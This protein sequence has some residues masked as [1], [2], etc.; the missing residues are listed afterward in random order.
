MNSTNKYFPDIAI[1]PGDHLIEILESIGM[2]QVELAER[3]GRPIKTINEIV[4]GKAALTPETALQLERVLNTPMKYWMNLESNYRGTLARIQDKELLLE[5]LAWLKA[6]PIKQMISYKWIAEVKEPFSQLEEVLRFF[7]VASIK[8]WEKVWERKLCGAFSYRKSEKCGMDNIALSTWLRKGELEASKIECGPY[9][10]ATF[11]KILTEFRGLTKVG[12]EVFVNELQKKCA[13]TGVAV[14]FVQELPK[15]PVNGVTHWVSSKK[16]VIQLSLRY[17]T[18]DQLW[19]SFF[20]EAGHI[21]VHGK[22]DFVDNGVD[23]EE[24][25]VWE[26]E[27][28]SFAADKLIPNSAYE[29]FIKCNVFSEASITQFAQSQ[30]V[31]SGIVVGRLQHDNYV[32]FNSRL[33]HLKKRFEWA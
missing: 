5:R 12:P 13:E 26:D 21:L 27:A 22:R 8:G 28:N 17:K 25:K 32:P 7:G 19:F 2:T 10:S 30:G 1:P 29:Y 3:M 23:A 20:H 14:V 31:A 4:K 11:E 33:N 16:A 24:N 18:D 6:V 15:V 9:D